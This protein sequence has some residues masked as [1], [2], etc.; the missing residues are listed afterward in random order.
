MPQKGESVMTQVHELADATRFREVL[1]RFPTGVVAV[2]A[3]DGSTPLGLT[4]GSFMSVSLEPQLV[5]FCI[6]GSSS[7]WP[8]MRHLGH[9]CV[10]VIGSDD[11]GMCERFG[12]RD[13]DRFEGQAW[14]LSPG[15]SPILENAIA[16]VDC[17]AETL[18]PLGDHELVVGR[19]TDLGLGREADP[20]LFFGKRF[21]R[22]AGLPAASQRP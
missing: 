1:G 16:W 22:F 8:L 14:R 5:A 10:N 9:F 20:L 4:I 7:T 6:A 12:R 21:G 13:V 17:L 15:G 18:V 3:H 11:A 19:V 2:T